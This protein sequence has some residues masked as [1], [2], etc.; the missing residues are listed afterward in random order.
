MD[1]FLRKETPAKTTQ[2]KD[3]KTEEKKSV[4][5]TDFFSKSTV[6]RVE[7]KHKKIEK[8]KVGMRSENFVICDWILSNFQDFLMFQA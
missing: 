5:V 1:K 4:S 3:K 8:E 2:I 7:S 6:Q